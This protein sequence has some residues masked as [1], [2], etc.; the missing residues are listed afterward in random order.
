M[1]IFAQNKVCRCSIYAVVSVV[2]LLIFSTSTSPLT[3][4]Y[5]FDSAFFTLVGQGI[6]RGLLPYRDFFDMKGPYLF[7]FEYLGQLLWPGRTGAFVLQWVNLSACLWVVDSIYTSE[8]KL[9]AL[10]SFKNFIKLFFVGFAPVLIVA[11]FTFERGNL[12]EELSLLFLLLAMKFMLTY[13]KKTEADNTYPHPLK[14][15]FCYGVF[16]GILA[17]I[18]ITNAALIGAVVLTIAIE[19]IWG[20]QFKN[21]I[22]NG[23]MF[24]AGVCAAFAPMVLYFHLNGL[25][26]E[27]LYQVFAFGFTYSSEFT[28]LEKVLSTCAQHW[29]IVLAMLFPVFVTFILSPKNRKYCVF[30]VSSFVLLMIAVCMGNGYMHYFTLGLPNIVFGLLMILKQD[31]LSRFSTGRK[32]IL[33]T[34]CVALSLLQMPSFVIAGGACATRILNLKN[35]R[36]CSQ[37]LEIKSHI[38]EEDYSKVYAYTKT[39][40]SAWYQIADLFPPN[41]YCDWQDHYMALSPKIKEEF[42]HYFEESGPEWLVTSTTRPIESKEINEIIDA[43]YTLYAENDM[44]RLFKRK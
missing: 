18:R 11:A 20:K 29:A 7:F 41:R 24:I 16:F 36:T 6:T 8:L 3:D 25:L 27:M 32:W 2:F 42:T 4:A 21:L 44:F 12:T 43:E 17:L 35:D 22:L 1:K 39:S 28:F 14:Y 9:F 40:C 5:G 37:V 13:F 33:A 30:S 26:S 38:P 31:G 19:L 23:L 10:D 15:G 34:V